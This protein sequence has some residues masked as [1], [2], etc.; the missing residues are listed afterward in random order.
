MIV[1]CLLDF[2]GEGPVCLQNPP[3]RDCGTAEEVQL[4]EEAQ[5]LRPHTFTRSHIVQHLRLVVT[6][7]SLRVRV[8]A[9][10]MFHVPAVFQGAVLAA[11]SSHKFNSFYGD[12]PEEIHDFSDDPTSS[13]THTQTH[14]TLSSPTH[15][16]PQIS[17]LSGL[18]YGCSAFSVRP[19]LGHCCCWYSL[20]I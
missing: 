7:P 16:L 3:A 13:G 12:P 19:C 10:P 1:F 4:Q 15:F 14:V 5:G 2:S 18:F 6:T 17:F 20:D 9:L 11:V 8:S